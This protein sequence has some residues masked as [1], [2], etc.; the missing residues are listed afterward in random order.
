M[1]NMS[2][3]T[4]ILLGIATAWPIVYMGLFMAFMFGSFFFTFMTEMHHSGAGPEAFPIAFVVLFALHFLTMLWILGLLVFY[5][6]HVF[7]TNRVPKDQ[8]ALWAVVLF[9]GGPLAM[10]VYWYLYIWREP[11]P[12]EG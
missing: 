10:P 8:K 2:R 7:Q 1:N 5:I 12:E 11:R 6:L 9:L 3:T 4:K